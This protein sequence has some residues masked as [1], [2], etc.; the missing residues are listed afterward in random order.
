MNANRNVLG[1]TEALLNKQKFTRLEKNLP[2]D[3]AE[4]NTGVLLKDLAVDYPSL[5]DAATKEPNLK[6]YPMLGTLPVPERESCRNVI[7]LLSKCKNEKGIAT[8]EC[9]QNLWAN[10]YLAIQCQKK[11]FVGGAIGVKDE[12]EDLQ[13]DG[14]SRFG[15]ANLM[16]ALKRGTQVSSAPQKDFSIKESL[17]KRVSKALNEEFKRI[18]KF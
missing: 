11:N 10:K 7:K 16:A 14:T 1:D 9:Y 13:T 17:D 8:T 15:L 3:S 6:V 12:F 2:P 5:S 4:A 18:F